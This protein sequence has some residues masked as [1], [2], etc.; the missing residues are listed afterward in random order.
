MSMLL[1]QLETCRVAVNDDRETVTM[2]DVKDYDAL[3]QLRATADSMVKVADEIA[4][5]VGA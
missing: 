3:D 1:D 4:A 5:M 2:L